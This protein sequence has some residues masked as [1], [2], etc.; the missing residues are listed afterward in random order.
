MLFP[1]YQE[2]GKCLRQGLDQKGVLVSGAEMGLRALVSLDL[3]T[4]LG[5]GLDSPQSQ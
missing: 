5:R 3:G 2:M 1:L 4:Y